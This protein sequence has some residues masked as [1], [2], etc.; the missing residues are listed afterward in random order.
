MR[1]RLL[2][3]LAVL[4]AIL[5]AAGWLWMRPEPPPDWGEIPPTGGVPVSTGGGPAR[6]R[7]FDTIAPH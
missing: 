3:L 2:G 6:V 1:T 4:L 7:P 5:L